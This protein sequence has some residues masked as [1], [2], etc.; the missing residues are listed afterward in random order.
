VQVAD[1]VFDGSWTEIV[2]KMRDADA[3]YA[4]RTLHDFMVAEARRAHSRSGAQIP[5]DDPERFIRGSAD[6]GL[7]R[8][9]R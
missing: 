9:V 5:A 2:R 1:T 3:S 4:G 7:L 8:I 6:A